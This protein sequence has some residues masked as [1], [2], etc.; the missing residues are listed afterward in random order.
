MVGSGRNDAILEPFTAVEATAP[1]AE[2]RGRDKN[3][4]IL[5]AC[6]CLTSEGYNLDDSADADCGPSR[7]TYLYAKRSVG[8]RDRRRSP[9]VL[10]DAS[11]QAKIARGRVEPPALDPPAK[12]GRM[13]S[14]ER[15]RGDYRGCCIAAQGIAVE[16]GSVGLHGD[17]F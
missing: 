10:S 2:V 5:T 7:P 14:A 16:P 11:I 6:R 4:K 8:W 15:V 12:S 3:L 17:S 13:Q 9:G 1:P